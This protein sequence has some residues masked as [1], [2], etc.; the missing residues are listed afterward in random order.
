MRLGFEALDLPEPW[1]NVPVVLAGV[2][3]APD[4]AFWR[5]RVLIEVE[6]DQHRTDRAQWLKDLARSNLV[7][8]LGLEQYRVT[9]STPTSTARDLA[10]IAARIRARH[11]PDAEFPRI[12]EFFDGIPEFGEVR[13]WEG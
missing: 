4:A 7:Q 13:W 3:L 5:S 2:T 6:G 8:R 11:R 12:A 10:P 9:V 1:C